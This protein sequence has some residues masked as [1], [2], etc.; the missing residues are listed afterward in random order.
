MGKDPLIDFDSFLRLSNHLLNIA[1]EKGIS[2]LSYEKKLGRSNLMNRSW[3]FPTYLE[4]PG[5]L[6]MEWSDYISGL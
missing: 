2:L 1:H 4:I 6:E 3:I 5:H